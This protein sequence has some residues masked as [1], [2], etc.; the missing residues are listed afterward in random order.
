LAGEKKTELV[1]FGVGLAG[2]EKSGKKGG[3]KREKKREK[4]EI[5]IQIEIEKKRKLCRQEFSGHAPS[6]ENFRYDV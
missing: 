1:C 5:E 3:K 2:E 4:N 6:R